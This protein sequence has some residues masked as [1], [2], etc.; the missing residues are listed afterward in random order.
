LSDTIALVLS[1]R[2]QVHSK[3][4]DELPEE[5]VAELRRPLESLELP[6]PG[7]T[8]LRVHG[9]RTVGGLVVR[10]RWELRCALGARAF[11][12]LAGAVSRLG[13]Q[14]GVSIAGLPPEPL[15]VLSRAVRRNYFKDSGLFS[16]PRKTKIPRATASIEDAPAT[17]LIDLDRKHVDELPPEVVAELLAPVEELELPF[18]AASVLRSLDVRRVAELICCSPEEILILPNAGPKTLWSINAGLALRG[19]RLGTRLQGCDRERLDAL[20]ERLGG[21]LPKSRAAHAAAEVFG[22]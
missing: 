19:L 4:V 17:S 11:V 3:H 18:R 1:P 9:L 10:S 13:L 6:E 7:K 15:V 20:R 21:E 16:A 14:L 12:P 22:E 5:V 2:V 8:L